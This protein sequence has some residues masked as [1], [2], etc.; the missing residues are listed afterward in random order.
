M[1]YAHSLQRQPHKL[2]NYLSAEPVAVLNITTILS[3]V[4]Y[5]LSIPKT[6]L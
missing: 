6:N 3:I 5:T 4:S 1:E 2:T